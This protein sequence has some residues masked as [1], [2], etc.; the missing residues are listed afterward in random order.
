MWGAEPCP[1]AGTAVRFSLGF[2]VHD[3]LRTCLVDGCDAETQWEK[4]PRSAQT[5]PVVGAER[6]EVMPLV[7]YRASAVASWSEIHEVAAP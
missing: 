3:A 4:P 2:A 1:I 6:S 5:S 7:S